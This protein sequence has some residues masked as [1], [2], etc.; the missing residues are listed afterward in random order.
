[1]QRVASLYVSSEAFMQR[2]SFK[3]RPRSE[4]EIIDKN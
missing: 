1:M 3:R 2:L 4:F